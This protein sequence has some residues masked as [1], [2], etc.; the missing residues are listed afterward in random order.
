MAD[1]NR[2]LILSGVPA[3]AVP[4]VLT[5]AWG[6]SRNELGSIIAG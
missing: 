1:I 3:L 5:R 2:R 6:G 4:A